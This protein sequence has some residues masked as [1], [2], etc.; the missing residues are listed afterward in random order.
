[1]LE[2]VAV[3]YIVLQGFA[4]Y[5]CVLQLGVVWRS[6]HEHVIHLLALCCAAGCCDELQGVAVC[7]SV[8][9]YVA[10]CCNVLQGDVE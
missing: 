10:A 5:C 8:L 6:V 9:Y 7:Y 4:G 1:V 3:C 2:F